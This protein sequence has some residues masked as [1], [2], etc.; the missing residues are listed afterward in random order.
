M[1]RFF[2]HHRLSVSVALFLVVA[3]LTALVIQHRNQPDPAI[4]ATVEYGPVRQLVSVSGIAEATQHA[5]LAFPVVGITKAIPAKVGDYVEAGEILAIL[6]T[7]TLET[8]RTEALAGLSSAVAD[9]GELITGP[10]AQDRV[11]TDET[12]NIQKDTLATTKLIEANKVN[13]AKRALLSSGLTAY[14]NDDKETAP[15]PEISGTY[16][17]EKEGVYTLSVYRSDSPSGYSYRLSGLETGSYTV[18]TEQPI[19]LGTCGLR[20]KFDSDSQYG[21]SIWYIEIPNTQSATYTI[22]KNAYELAQVQASTSIALAEQ[23]VTLAEATA[24]NT[25]DIP[26]TE[27]LI[28]ADAKVTQAQARVHRVE[29]QIAERVMRAP[30]S[31]TITDIA[32][33]TGETATTEPVITLVAGGEFEITARIPE[34]DIGKL[35]VGQK[36]EMVFDAKNTE[37]VT[38]T[39]SFLSLE[40]T[41]IDGV[42]YFDAH[43]VLDSQPDWIRSG[44]NADIDIILAEKA[45]ELRIPKR[46]LTQSGDTP[47]VLKRTGEQVAST[48][49]EVLLEGNDGYVAISGLTSGD[50]V[51]AP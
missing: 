43:I 48:S 14:T 25:N 21:N 44:L 41:D 1:K 26:R 28:R 38:G 47:L 51:V 31:G 6:D 19:P 5:N 13:N 42:A 50:T 18:S 46:F 20:I 4:T 22:N 16:S 45:N 39:V 32:I 40:A 10:T 33:K 23:E 7:S 37:T 34:I 17:C 8:D 2:R 49:I 29:S 3:L 35:S 12:V 27:E 9:R 11:V 24:A 36:A 15:A 30:F